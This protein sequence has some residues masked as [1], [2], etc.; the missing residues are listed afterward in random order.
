M[1]PQIILHAKDENKPLHYLVIFETMADR[2]RWILQN[3]FRFNP[4]ENMLARWTKPNNGPES[5]NWLEMYP[6]APEHRQEIRALSMMVVA[7]K[8]SK[9][10]EYPPYDRDDGQDGNLDK[11][12][13]KQ[14]LAAQARIEIDALLG[15]HPNRNA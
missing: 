3:G 2:T 15:I 11:P 12:S 7:H 9:Q 10:T 13:E 1:N 14:C 6:M 5:K 8:N 4:T